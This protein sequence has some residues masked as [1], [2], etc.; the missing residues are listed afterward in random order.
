MKL[1][2]G[3]QMIDAALDFPGRMRIAAE[4][5]FDGVELWLGTPDL[6]LEH[7]D[8]DIR[9]L[10]AVLRDHGL[11]CS[12]VASTLGWKALITDPDEAVFQRAL[13][14][15]RRQIEAAV[16]LGADGVLVVTGQVLP[17]VPFCQAWR[18]LV[19]GF[20]ELGAYAAARGVRVGAETCPKLSKNLMTPGECLSFVRDVDSPAVGVYL[21]T[22]NVLHSGYPH[23]FIRTL[24]T[25][26]VRLHGKDVLPADAQ[27]RQAST[28]PGQG[29]I[30]WAE[31]VAACAEV[32]Y[33]GWMALEF[34]PP[35]GQ[36]YG[37]GLCRA[38]VASARQVG[39][40]PAAR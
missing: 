3:N 24:G 22:A 11:A 18:R 5:G 1:S 32:G 25:H 36:S 9:R 2:I 33:A 37:A 14:V 21:D 28:W 38:A 34:G 40:L 15:S 20:R 30:D 19:S 7:S 35:A 8:D 23:D 16:L 12:S 31:V 13:A 27:G 6:T 39:I 10:G 29:V 4:A 26:L 17:Q